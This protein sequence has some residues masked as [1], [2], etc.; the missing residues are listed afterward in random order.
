MPSSHIVSLCGDCCVA[1]A[2]FVHHILRSA[3][4]SSLPTVVDCSGVEQ[5]DASFI[6]LLISGQ[7][8]FRIRGLNFRI[9]DAA[10]ALHA[11]LARA[12]LHIDPATGQIS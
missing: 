12:G 10:D 2:Q 9:V 6:Q 7:K 3:A 11:A 5:A 1:R 4:E 8:T